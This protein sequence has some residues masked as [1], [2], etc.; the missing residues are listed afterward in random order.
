[1]LKV[2]NLSDQ[3]KIEICNWKYEGEYAMYNF[4]SY[5][6]MKKEQKIFFNPNLRSKY[7]T[8]RNEEGLVGFTNICEEDTEVFMGIGVNPTLCNK[9]YGQELM[10]MAILQAN[11]LY[12]NKPLYLE[13]RNWNKRAIHCYK[14][15]GFEI[16][17]D[18]I[19]QETYVGI[20]T[21]V[22]MIRK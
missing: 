12:P 10:K 21:F 16:D 17:G 18:E 4:P 15:V 22:R 14:K 6:E 9:G 13:V 5:E 2:T 7:R 3:D 8:Y 1:M 19:I 11:E 20:G